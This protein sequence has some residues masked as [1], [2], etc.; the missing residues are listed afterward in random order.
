VAEDLLELRSDE[1]CVR[2][3]ARLGAR[4][5]SLSDRHGNEFVEVGTPPLEEIT[6]SHSFLAGGL[7]GIDDCFP[8]ITAERLTSPERIVPD[9]GEVWCRP[10]TVLDATAQRIVTTQQGIESDFE[11]NRVFELRGTSLRVDYELRNLTETPFEALWAAHPLFVLTPDTRLDL[12]TI[13]HVR[14]ES[15][16]MTPKELD[17][18]RPGA[19]PDGNCLKAFAPLPTGAI[20]SVSYPAIGRRISMHLEAERPAWLGIWINAGGFPE[21]APVRHLALEPTFGDCDALSQAI[22]SDT[23]LRLAPGAATTWSLTYSVDATVG[24]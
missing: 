5:V 19:V 18:T 23:C 6:P 8:G 2:L 17:L 9:H 20:V 13:A 22:A 3:A 12:S 7:G 21:D 10:V 24:D 16:T 1:L 14:V 11:L 15:G 4:I